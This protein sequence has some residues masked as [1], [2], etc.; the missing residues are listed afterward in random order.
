MAEGKDSNRHGMK[1]ILDGSMPR[2]GPDERGFCIPKCMW[3]RCSRHA[4]KTRS[5]IL[6]CDWI[7]G[8]CIGPSCTYA[9]CLRGKMMTDNR[10]GLVV[11]RVTTDTIKPDDFKLDFK[12]SRK[13]TRRLG[14]DEDIV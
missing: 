11:R 10:C 7:E 2:E 8:E 1:L 3:F 14:R 4:L 5:S 9:Q 6:W 12:I 13:L